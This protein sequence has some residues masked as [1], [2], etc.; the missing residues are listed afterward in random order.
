MKYL[1]KKIINKFI[2]LFSSRGQLQV[3]EALGFSQKITR[4]IIKSLRIST[5]LPEFIARKRLAKK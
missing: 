1:I 5:N 3:L 4:Y 2:F